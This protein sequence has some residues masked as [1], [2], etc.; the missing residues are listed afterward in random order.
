MADSDLD[1]VDLLSDSDDGAQGSE[2]REEK[3][4]RS[5]AKV[6]TVS[7]PVGPCCLYRALPGAFR[8][9]LRRPKIAR[10]SCGLCLHTAI[11]RGQER[12]SLWSSSRSRLLLVV[13]LGM[14]HLD[15]Q[16]CSAF[17]V[18]SAK[19]MH[20]TSR[21]TQASAKATRKPT[22]N[23]LGGAS[24]R[25]GQGG[26]ASPDMLDQEI[27]RIKVLLREREREREEAEKKFRESPSFAAVEALALHFVRRSRCV[28]T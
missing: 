3:N 2:H 18:T 6:T 17:T 9:V 28:L 24:G 7:S 15:S 19:V 23:S 20:E 13:L 25:V 14:H 8:R 26:R 27:Q 10:G 16:A 4:V 12:V 21:K 22:A 5:P 11:P 1:C